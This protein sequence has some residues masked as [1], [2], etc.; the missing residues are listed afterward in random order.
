MIRLSLDR[1]PL[2]VSLT[3]PLEGGR[4]TLRRLASHELEAARA[5]ALAVVRSPAQLIELLETHDLWPVDPATGRRRKSKEF[6]ADPMFMTGIG[7]W[8][9]AVECG[10]RAITAWSGF[11]DDQ[12]REIP[13]SR[14]ALEVAFLDGAFLDQVQRAMSRSAQMLVV[15]GKGS[16]ASPSGSSAPGRTASAPS[17]A[18]TAESAGSPV[19]PASRTEPGACAPRSSSRRS[20]RKARPSGSS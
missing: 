11:A 3:G 20:P 5:A 8:L 13:V 17:T 10:V 15:E 16:G 12:G 14:A 18:T 4:L 2:E 7:E 6:L 9:G 19:R 1:E